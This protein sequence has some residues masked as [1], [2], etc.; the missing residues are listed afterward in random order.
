MKKF[1]GLGLLG[2]IILLW[3]LKGDNNAVKG[4]AFSSSEQNTS[5]QLDSIYDMER[6][7]NP[8]IESDNSDVMMP[9]LGNQT[10]RAELGH[11]TWHF[12]HTLAGRFPVDPTKDQQKAVLQ[13][14]HLFSQLYPCGNCAGHFQ[15][16][17]KEDPPI[18]KSR[19]DFV[20]W[21]C[22][23]H[24]KVNVRLKKPMFDCS[25]IFER[26]QCGCIES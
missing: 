19:E 20:Y 9:Y 26:W 8:P 14:I 24:N 5:V 2:I 15:L 10:Q 12:L 17:L 13:F 6:Y 4:T 25:T 7:I 22:R 18:V 1:A 21:F 11:S 16:L 23:Q 3:V